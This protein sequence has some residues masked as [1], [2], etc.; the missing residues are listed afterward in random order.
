MSDAPTPSVAAAPTSGVKRRW[1]FAILAL[2]FL[3]VLMPF[4]FWQATWFG[5]PLTDEDLQKQLSDNEHP[6]KIQHALAQM[7]ERMNR[8]ELSVK[9]WYP[10]LVELSGHRV[11]EIRTT[12]AWVMGH[13]QSV[14]TF[15]T[16]LVS[17]LT[18]SNPMVRRNAALALVRFGDDS[19]HADVIAMLRAH[20]VV[21][22]QAGTL[23][24]RLQPGDAVNPG[25]MV[26]RIKVGEL[27]TEVRSRVPGT[28]QRWLVGDGAPVKP[29]QEL[30]LL[31]PSAEMV[32][33]ALRGLVLVGRAEDLADVERYARGVSGMPPAIARQAEE[34][35]IAIE[36]RVRMQ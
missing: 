30:V 28:V 34:T 12:A 32:W 24:Q 3:F 22:P 29:G 14:P 35:K 18:D 20:A 31:E 4:L 7:A 11:D 13:D 6:R 36:Q 25:T 15:H 19:G 17:L 9:Q 26:G 33:E 21:S 1:A 10:K 8:R 23:D 5:R 16:A 2:A 27:E